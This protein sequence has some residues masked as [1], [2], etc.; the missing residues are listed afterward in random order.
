MNPWTWIIPF[1]I[2]IG[3]AAGAAVLGIKGVNQLTGYFSRKTKRSRT[4]EAKPRSKPRAKK[5]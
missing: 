5:K 3:I 1:A 2:A 4:V